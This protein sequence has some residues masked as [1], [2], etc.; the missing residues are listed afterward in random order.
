MSFSQLCFNFNFF[1]VISLISKVLEIQVYQERPCQSI[2]SSQASLHEAFWSLHSKWCQTSHY[3][4]Q[5]WIM[6]ESLNKNLVSFHDQ[7]VH[8]ILI[9]GLLFSC[10]PPYIFHPKSYS[11]LWITCWKTFFQSLS[12]KLYKPL[13]RL[14]INTIRRAP[15]KQ[16]LLKVCVWSCN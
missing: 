5:L 15:L 9:Q 16:G 13:R 3:K 6:W 14:L 7:G 8:A 4:C 11:L 1:N 10:Y 2:Y 12:T